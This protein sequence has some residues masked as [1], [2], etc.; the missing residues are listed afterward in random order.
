MTTK[1]NSTDFW[2]TLLDSFY[3]DGLAG[4]ELK[5]ID[6]ETQEKLLAYFKTKVEAG[7]SDGQTA[8]RHFRLVFTT[9]FGVF[10]RRCN[11]N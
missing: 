6:G 10:L 2:Y 5:E 9:T 1:D 11:Q 8:R 3:N 7:V 4:D